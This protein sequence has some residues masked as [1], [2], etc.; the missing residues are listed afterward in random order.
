M[1]DPRAILTTLSMTAAPGPSGRLLCGT[2]LSGLLTAALPAAAL[3]GKPLP[4]PVGRYPAATLPTD[5]PDNVPHTLAETL[6]IAYE[7]NPQLT[8]ERAHLRATDEDVPAALAG[9]RPTVTVQAA[10]GSAVG[11]FDEPGQCGAPSF[12]LSGEIPPPGQYQGACY[13]NGKV[14]PNTISSKT[15]NAAGEYTV[16]QLDNRTLHSE[17]ATITQYLYRGGHTTSSTH[18]AV[19]NVYAERARLIAEEE[20]VFSDTINAYVTFIE[21]QQLLNLDRQNEQ[22]LGDE[23]RA[24]NDQFR[25]GELT[26][27]D[28]AQAEAALAQAIAVRQTAEGTLETA[29][30]TFVRQ[31]GVTPPADLAD[32]QPLRLPVRSE[33]EASD[34][35]AR[36]NPN[37]IAGLFNEAQ[38]KDAIDIAFSNLGPQIYVQGQG[39]QQDGETIRGDDTYGVMA[40]INLTMPLYQGGSE[41]AAIRQ[42]RQTY[43]QAV[44]ETEDARRSA[45]ELA[46]QAWDTLEAARA[47]TISSRIAVRSAEI[48][49]EG[50]EREALVGSATVQ[51]VLIQQQNL[52]SAQITLV[53]NITSIV[54][55]SY[56]VASAIGRL[57]AKDLGLAVPLYDETAYYNAVRD[58]LWGTGDYAVHQPG[59]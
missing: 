33:K 34:L 59:R 11:R 13:T 58:R 28:V 53:Q 23:L 4:N 37:V 12:S 51:E 50:T 30:A 47:S 5:E 15:Y 42:A 10:W 21:D 25:V 17:T 32:P 26:R 31:V 6:G 24:V 2:V 43:Q 46:V 29:R 57:T 39:F 40:T 16:S 38:A 27:T 54:T 41:Y 35:A 48:A 19:N 36:N 14:P 56:G 18:Q 45:R 49:V 52:L 9:W 22:V 7:T 8:G 55:A 3:A 20:T 1:R 44:R